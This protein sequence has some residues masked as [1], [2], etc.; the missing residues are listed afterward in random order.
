MHASPGFAHPAGGTEPHG[1]SRFLHL[2]VT[3]KLLVL[4][5][6]TVIGI[7]AFALLAYNTLDNVK[8]NGPV[9]DRIKQQQDL[10][11]DILPPPEYII[12]AYLVVLQMEGETNR[13]RIDALA[14][15]LDKLRED[16]ENRHGF[17][18]QLPDGEIKKT[19]LVTSYQP[20]VEFLR[21]AQGDYLNAVYQGNQAR[22]R[23]LAHG[24]LAE[25]YEQHRAAIDRVVELARAENVAEETR[26]KELV[27]S[28][29]IQLVLLGIGLILLVL[30]L[31]GWIAAAISR[32]LRKVSHDI[33]GFCSEVAATINEQERVLSVQAA[34]VNETTT[35]MSELDASF[36]HAG[37]VATSASERARSALA[38]ADGTHRNGSTSTSATSS[39]KEKIGA[40]TQRLLELSERTTQ[41]GSMSRAVE[42]LANQTNLLALN[43]AVEAARAG[44]NGRGFAVVAGEI[45]KLADESKRSGER[46]E[47]LVNEIQNAT[48]STVM[49]M[50]EGTRAVG[51]V[52]HALETLQEISQQSAMG[53]QEQITA[54]RQ[55]VQAMETL[56]AGAHD[57]ATGITQTK[58]GIRTLTQTAETLAEMV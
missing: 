58:G 7:C 42:D 34:S 22:E 47:A 6:I 53:I 50:E 13:A 48:N 55:V 20:A 35:T 51:E 8:V 23:Q 10:I 36:R 43:A 31:S 57:A 46:I 33:T 14:R 3:G 24:P 9:Y 21:L 16:Y 17:W 1:R 49:S 5:T 27:R 18:A 25:K 41:I 26:A 40:V 15:Q 52:V 29:T 56:N 2:K 38:L 28:S 11:A 39:L 12:E 19:L 37:E 4:V 30:L 32:P 44:E 54:V 45:R